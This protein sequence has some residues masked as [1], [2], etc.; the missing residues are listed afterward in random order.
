M[1]T[2]LHENHTYPVAA[3]CRL[4]AVPRS[5]Y[6]YA[7]EATTASPVRQAVQAVAAEFPTYGSRRIAAQL[8]RAPYA[9]RVNRKQ[10]QRLM[11]E[12]GLLRPVKRRVRPTTNSQHPWP[13]YPHLVLNRQV[14]LPDEVWVADITYVK[15][16]SEFIYLAVVMDVFTRT[17]RGWQLSRWLDQSLTLAA[18][19]RALAQHGPPQIHHS[20]QGVQYAARAYVEQLQAFQIKIS[21]AEVGAAW[22]NGYAERIIRTIKEEEIDL[23]DYQDFA[24]AYAQIGH[25]VEQV[26]QHKRIHSALGYLTPAEFAAD[27]R[28]Q[29][30]PPSLT[31]V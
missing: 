21:M 18:L 30:Q 26:Y 12:L 24:D 29:H 19:Q 23:A 22:Q 2:T 25:F 16:R 10:V 27:W 14:T 5:R 4:L 31:I 7:S 8:R 3:L 9:L 1:V 17:S 13:R 11:R 20:D 6:Y 28:Q 15:L